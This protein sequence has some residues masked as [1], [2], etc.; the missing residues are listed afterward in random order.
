MT[1]WIR[2]GKAKMFTK[3]PNDAIDSVTGG[4]VSLQPPTGTKA[5]VWTAEK[6]Q[7]DHQD[8]GW[9]MR[10]P[11]L[12]WMQ[13]LRGAMAAV[14]DA[15]NNCIPITSV[16]DVGWWKRPYYALARRPGTDSL[17]NLIMGRRTEGGQEVKWVT[18]LN[19]VTT[20]DGLILRWT[21]HWEPCEISIQEAMDGIQDLTSWNMADRSVNLNALEKSTRRVK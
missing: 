1:C 14:W 4:V 7:P 6:L 5:A 17:I 15:Q 10:G 18:L 2:D 13:P 8:V 11:G 3:M 16:L 20:Q 12:Y 9:W 21:I 19:T